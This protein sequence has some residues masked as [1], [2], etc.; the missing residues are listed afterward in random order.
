M[1]VNGV[2]S[3]SS[4]GSNRRSVEGV[5]AYTVFSSKFNVFC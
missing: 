5:I 2:I 3:A 4:A 1:A